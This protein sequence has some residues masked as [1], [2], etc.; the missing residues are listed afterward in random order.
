MSLGHQ[1][2]RELS[3]EPLMAMKMD[4]LPSASV[5]VCTT[6]WPSEREV[7]EYLE[8]S[9]C[10]LLRTASNEEMVASSKDVRIISPR[11]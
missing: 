4:G 11:R 8:I 3:L 6:A 2:F 5:V 10:M 1:K 7:R 9:S